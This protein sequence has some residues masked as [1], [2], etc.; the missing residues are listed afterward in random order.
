M[1]KYYFITTLLPPL[2]IG[3]PPEM[4]SRELDFILKLNLTKEDY[5]K[6]DILRRLIDIENIRAFWRKESID[7]GGNFDEKELEENLLHQEMLPPY[8]Y[9]FMEKYPETSSRLKN[10]P[11]LLR[12]FFQTEMKKEKD[13]V[14]D[15]LIFEWQWR[16]IF[17]VFRALSLERNVLSE[18]E[19]EDPDNPFI[20]DIIEQISTTKAYIPPE[21]FKALQGIYDMKK[22]SPLELELALSEWRFE[23]IEEMIGW[24]TFDIY[25]ILGYVIQLEIVEKWL[26]LDK[27]KGLQFIEKTMKGIA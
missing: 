10:F 27:R 24:H 15:Y 9:A 8:V 20:S 21:N 2:K 3:S 25:R 13:F 17:V 7:P 12:A 22:H 16:M 14:Q 26:E 11:E 23:R 4:G 6:V 1:A 18:L 5:H 19:H